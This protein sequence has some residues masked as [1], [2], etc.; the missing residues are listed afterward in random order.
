MEYHWEQQL[1]LPALIYRIYLV[2]EKNFQD[3]FILD[4]KKDELD[5]PHLYVHIRVER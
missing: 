3:R 1:N 4:F 2:G 5:T